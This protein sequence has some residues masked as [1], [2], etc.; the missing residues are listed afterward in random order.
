[1]NAIVLLHGLGANTLV[2]HL[3][4][5]NLRQP[6]CRIVNWGYPSYRLSITTHAAA[7]VLLL[8][9]LDQDPDVEKVH[10]VAHSMGNIVARTALLNRVPAKMGRMVMLAPPN[11][12]SRAASFFGPFLGRVC[13]PIEELSAREGSFVCSLPNP[14]G[15]EFGVI[16]AS[17]DFLVAPEL[18]QLDGEQDRVQVTSWHSGILFRRQ[19]AEQVKH[20]LA[21]GKFDRS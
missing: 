13:R 15:L 14:K 7:L 16:T 18:T 11:Q 10:L 2:M 5:R 3:L 8:E 17:H 12:G 20:F 6:N 4:A 9:K 21:H 19:T 1:M